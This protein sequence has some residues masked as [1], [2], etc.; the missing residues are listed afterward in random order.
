MEATERLEES[1][2][3]SGIDQFFYSKGGLN[4]F[5]L[6][7]NQFFI[8]PQKECK[9]V[10]NVTTNNDIIQDQTLK[11][12][13]KVVIFIFLLVRRLPTLYFPGK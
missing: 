11:S 10:V 1:F 4:N 3:V 2:I 12:T 13:K 5:G 8:Q 7:I 9:M 6:G